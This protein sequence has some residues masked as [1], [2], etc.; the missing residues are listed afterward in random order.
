[1]RQLTDREN[2]ILERTLRETLKE[3]AD[4]LKTGPEDAERM[5]RA[6]NQRIEE[7]GSMRRR[8]NIS[9]TAAVTAAICIIGAMTAVA[10]GKAT[11]S[12]SFSSHDDE[13]TQ[14]SQL[15]AAENEIG[16]D[17]KAPETF[18]NGYRFV[19]GVPVY[20][21][22]QDESGNV[23]QEQQDLSLTYSKEGQK[24]LYLDVSKSP[25]M[26]EE[27]AWDQTEEHGGITLGYSSNHYRMVPPDYEMTAEEIAQSEAGDLMIAYGS[28]KITDQTLQS[29]SWEDNGH[30]Y[31]LFG[32]DTGLSPED[33]YQMAGEI[34]DGK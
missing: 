4:A 34:I 5:C 25:L 2:E 29:L 22:G 1:M 30:L 23:V 16:F 17:V 12:Y 31:T 27:S 3:R 21:Q 19:S 6:V 18:S 15:T 11:M 13:F 8:W 9:K 10:A 7:E 26:D 24:D 28:D 33:F 14:Y 32:F 20:S